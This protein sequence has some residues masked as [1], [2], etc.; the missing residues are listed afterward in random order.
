MPPF[1]FLP[2]VF[3]SLFCVVLTCRV[4]QR[5]EGKV[6][7]ELNKETVLWLN[8]LSPCLWAQT[9]I[10]HTAAPS[11]DQV[12]VCVTVQG[13]VTSRISRMT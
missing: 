6:Q 5:E 9:I 7:I 10:P 2:H 1:I 11:C 8:A 13:W 4:V 3:T 12:S